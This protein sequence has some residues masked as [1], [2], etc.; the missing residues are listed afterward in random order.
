MGNAP[1]ASLMA[2]NL[3]QFETETQSFLL[4]T[5]ARYTLDALNQLA[6]CLNGLP[7]RKNL[8][9]FS[10]SFPVNILPDGGIANPFAAV[11]SAEDEYRETADLLSQSQ[12]AVYPIDVRSPAASPKGDSAER[13]TMLP[14][15]EA[16]GGQAFANTNGLTDA[17]K[18]S[19]DAGSNYYTLTWSPSN[20]EW[21]GEYRKIQIEIARPNLSLAYRRG[22]FADDPL[23]PAHRDE[24]AA[25]AYGPPP[26]NALHAASMRGGPDPTQIIFTASIAPTAAE[27]EA[28][29]AL[30]N[31]TNEKAKGPFRRYAIRLGVE[32]QDLVCPAMPEGVYQCKLQVEINVYNASGTVLDFANGDVQTNTPADQYA[33]VLRSGLH[34]RQDISI[35]AVGESFLRIAIRDPSTDKVGALEVPVDAFRNLPLPAIPAQR[36]DNPGNLN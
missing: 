35:P 13:G 14:M 12:V 11:A 19:I 1:S 5:R 2:A 18:Q 3:K 16:T 23:A 24:P 20:P 31:T 36:K 15:A 30:G 34:L 21:K 22:Y 7:G 9:W 33:Q 6:R 32:A 8:I 29:P 17:I 28:G 27:P 4:Q 26:Y 25:T 10:G